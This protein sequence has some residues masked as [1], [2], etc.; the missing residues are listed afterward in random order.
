[1]DI[2][3][4]SDDVAE[5]RKETIA[6]VAAITAEVAD[7]QPVNRQDKASP[8]FTKEIE[9]TVHKGDDPTPEVPFVETRE[10]LPEDQDP[11]PSMITF[12]KSFYTSYRGELLIVGY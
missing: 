12:N 8:E 6:P 11:S 7:P 9:M 4:F 2:D 5:V 10:N 1:V 3:N